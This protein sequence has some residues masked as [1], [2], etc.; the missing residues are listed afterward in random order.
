MK[1]LFLKNLVE[2][3]SSRQLFETLKKQGYD[4]KY[5]TFCGLLNRYQDYGYAEKKTQK[6]PFLFGLTSLGHQHAKNPY[7]A[8]DELA[9]KRMEFIYE[10][11]EKELAD[12][13]EALKNLSAQPNTLTIP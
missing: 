9:R 7:L 2:P 8:R 5:T 3:I 4:A 11:I 6:K 10:Q 12:H 13:P 1:Q